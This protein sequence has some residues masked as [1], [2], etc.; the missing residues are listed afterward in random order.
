M[1]GRPRHTRKDANQLEI[2]RDLRALGC[3]VWDL[4][5]LGGH[6]LDLI[7]FFQGQIRVVEVKA[8]G[9]PIVLTVGEVASIQ[10]LGCIGIEAVVAQDVEDV[11]AAFD[12]RKF[13]AREVKEEV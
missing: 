7:V 11:L 5:D 8:P 3:V 13:S 10:E 2:V 1:T 4:A 12:A 6:I 9:R